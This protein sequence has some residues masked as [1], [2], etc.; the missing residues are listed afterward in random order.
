MQQYECIEQARVIKGKCTRTGK[1]EAGLICKKN[2]SIILV[3]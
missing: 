2:S 1:K 3:N